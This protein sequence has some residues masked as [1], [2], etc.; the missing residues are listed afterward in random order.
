MKLTLQLQLLPSDAQR[1]DLLKTMAA[2]NAAASYAAEVGFAAMVYSQPSI[3]ARCYYEIRQRFGL[4]AQMAVRAIAKAVEVFKREKTKCPVFRPDGAITYDQRILSFKGLDRVSLWTLRGRELI[5]LVYGTY[6]AERFDRLKGQVDLVCRGGQFFLYATIELP[7][8]A[9]VDVQDFLGIDLG[10]ANLATTSD[11]EHFTGAVVEQVR[12][13]YTR[14]RQRLGKAAGAK[15]RQG[16]RPKNIRRALRRMK[17]RES[18]FRRDVNH[19]LSKRLVTQAKDSGKGIALEELTHIR[20]RTR[21]R[22]RQRAMM[23]GWAF[24][25]LRQFLTYKAALHGVVLVLVDPRYTSQTCSQ[26]GHCEK[27]NRSSQAIFLC[28]HCGF[29]CH[30][31]LNGARNIR[32]RALVNAPTE[33][34][35]LPET[36]AA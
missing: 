33:S 17:R 21:F 3:H 4:S 9:P 36:S 23:S 2:F 25:Q 8:G 5:P 30:A 16:K 31:D 12:Q 11:G 6:Q 35:Q 32:A 7:E 19:C 10:V 20:A 13:R 27:A 18:R 29:S 24:A 26:C 15:R 1:E 34:E 22:K 14:R 28:K